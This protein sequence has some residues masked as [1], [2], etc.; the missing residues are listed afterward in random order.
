MKKEVAPSNEETLN[1][2]YQFNDLAEGWHFRY[3]DISNG[4]YRVQDVDKW[5]RSVSRTCTETELQATLEACANDA[6]D[7][8][9]QL[10]EKI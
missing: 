1:S 4:V 3:V 9:R 2:L 7:I 5:G 10:Q 8:I 6:R